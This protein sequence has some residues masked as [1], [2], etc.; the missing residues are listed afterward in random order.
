MILKPSETARLQQLKAANPNVKVLMYKNLSASIDYPSNAYLTT[1]V[2]YDE[3]DTQH[4]EW[5]L[6]NTSGQRFT[7]RDYSNL[8]AMDVGSPS[9]QQRWADN[10]LKSLEHLGLRR[11]V[12]RRHQP[13]DEGSLRPHQGREVPDRRRVPA[14]HR[15]RS[16]EDHPAAPLRRL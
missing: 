13:D 3:A 2:S 16:R 1:G 10:V 12:H 7:H 5:F 6:L 14:G 9:Y 8:W 4:P 15:V 11:G